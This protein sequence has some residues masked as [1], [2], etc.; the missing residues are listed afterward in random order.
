MERVVERGPF[1]EA[2]KLKERGKELLQTFD[3]TD[4]FKYE[5]ANDH[6]DYIKLLIFFT[7]YSDTQMYEDKVKI[8]FHLMSDEQ[9]N[10]LDKKKDMISCSFGPAKHVIKILMT[11]VSKNTA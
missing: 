4:F 2:F 3:T 7:L 10:I 9:E 11:L 6:F 8:L 5:N 1:I